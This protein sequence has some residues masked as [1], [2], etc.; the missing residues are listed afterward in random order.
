MVF[1]EDAAQSWASADVES[2]DLVLTGD[3]LWQWLEWWAL[4]MP[5]CGLWL[6]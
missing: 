2:F 5:W 1:V 3:R 6:L 4:A